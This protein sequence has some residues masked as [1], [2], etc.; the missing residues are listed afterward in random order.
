MGSLKQ[1]N[2][3]FLEGVIALYTICGDIATT[4]TATTCSVYVKDPLILVT[5]LEDTQYNSWIG[6][7]KITFLRFKKRKHTCGSSS[8]LLIFLAS[9]C[10]FGII[11][12]LEA[13]RTSYPAHFTA[14]SQ[15]DVICPISWKNG[16]AP[17]ATALIHGCIKRRGST[18][19]SWG[20]LSWVL[21]LGHS[22]MR[23]CTISGPYISPGRLEAGFWISD[24]LWAISAAAWTNKNT[25]IPTA[26]SI[27]N[28]AK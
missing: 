8:L 9:R 25:F 28:K 2:C 3:T 15:T 20:L 7:C 1:D 13:R 18:S 22:F 5:L 10:E 24:E 19:L 21:D 16:S 14:L 27:L 26:V 11:E 6:L 4:V 23:R 12:I 17:D